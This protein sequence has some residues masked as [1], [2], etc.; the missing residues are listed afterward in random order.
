[1][2]KKQIGIGMLLLMAI[3]FLPVITADECGGG[4][5][6]LNMSLIVT[7]PV[8]VDIT[9]PL[10]NYDYFVTQLNYTVS[11]GLVPDSCW[12]SKDGGT[13]NSTPISSGTN[14]VGVT[15]SE[16]LN[17]WNVYC[18]DS[19]NDLGYDS[20]EFRIDTIQPSGQT[21]GGGGSRPYNNSQTPTNPMN[22]TINASDI[23]GS[24]IQNVT[25]TIT[26]E[27]G[28]ILDIITT[29]AGGI[30]SG[31][32]GFMYEF[33]FVG[34]Y[35]WFFEVV[36]VVGNV[37]LSETNTVTFDDTNPT[38]AI[39]YP[40][41]FIYDHQITAMNFSFNTTGANNCWYN[42]GGSDVPITCGV[43]ATGLASS[44]GENTWRFWVND[45]TG[46]INESSVTFTQDTTFP[47]ITIIA[48]VPLVYY[49]SLSVPLD[50]LVTD[51]T[52]DI[53]SIWWNVDGG[54]PEFYYNSTFE[55]FTEA[56]HD[57]QVWANDS[58]GNINTTTMTFLVDLTPPSITIDDVGFI[59]ARELPVLQ[60][61]T[62]YVP[63][64]EIT[65]CWFEIWNATSTGNYL[66]AND[67]LPCV[68]MGTYELNLSAQGMYNLDVYGKTDANFTSSDGT[69]VFVMYHP[70]TQS[71]STNETSEGAIV[72]F[73][74]VIDYTF[75]T[76]TIAELVYD[77]V[78]YPIDSYDVVDETVYIYKALTIPDGTGGA[79]VED[80][81]W[82]WVYEMSVIHTEFSTE[83][84][85]QRVHALNIDDCSVYSDVILHWD[86]NDEE[87]DIAM[88]VDNST[89]VE[90][91]VRITS[92]GD[93]EVYW[94]FSKQW[95]EEQSGS[96]CIPDGM[97][98]YSSYLFE[99]VVGYEQDNWVQEFWHLDNG[100]LTLNLFPYDSWT[101]RNITL[102]DLKLDD[103]ST[104]LLK[105]YDDHYLIHPEAIVILE[106][107]Y[108]GEGVFKEVERCKLDNNGECHLHLVEEDVIYRFKVIEDGLLEYGSGEYNAKCVETPC[109]ITLTKG[110]EAQEWETEFDNLP[111]GTYTLQINESSRTVLLTF[112]LDETGDMQLDIFVYSNVINS[113]DTLVVSDNAIAKTGQVEV[114]IPLSYGNVSYYAV[115]RH[116][117]GFVASTWVDLNESG[118]NYFGN[119][120]LFLGALLVL[121]LGLIAVS[122]GGWTIVF[123]ILGLLVASI[124]KLID[125]DFYLI[126]WVIAVGGLIT[127]KLSTRRSI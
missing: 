121:T 49:T 110:T 2:N 39:D 62:Y 19:V 108:I 64:V 52:T 86:L 54:S 63:D 81:N 38:G 48:P 26:N 82:H 13:T 125:M 46:F 51:A 89:D 104:F 5:C 53:D 78:R 85:T 11:G 33:L 20:E 70:Y 24:G 69:F 37:F 68:A 116:N 59:S 25:F 8:V 123:I 29:D 113:P 79:I 83:N 92:L 84:V 102:M 32:F 74:L 106:R 35:E 45:T 67:T 55:N 97:L 100:D 127:W 98:G 118:Y 109:R 94:E 43:N 117:D 66:V 28:G 119:L 107:K 99:G 30:F 23:N 17:T 73:E 60:N 42:A 22:F 91:E 57:L 88:S 96:I 56:S 27:T 71:A 95:I 1:M 93:P 115:V 114:S 65:S 10:T 16:G 105:Y 103:S 34:V 44:E 31:M 4:S 15:G 7:N 87:T 9:F 58:A 122:S 47:Q 50:F 14:F 90:A 40:I 6:P 75:Y 77:G 41:V 36:D 101:N 61:F 3:V 18:N 76:N 112:N 124:T 72:D 12:Y 21:G 80:V 126:M 111:E 120:G